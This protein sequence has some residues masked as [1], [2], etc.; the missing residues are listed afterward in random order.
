MILWFDI[1]IF[2]VSFSIYSLA[3][4]NKY[5]T[6]HWVKVLVTQLCPTLCDPINCSPPSSSVGRILQARILEWVAIPFSRGSSQS[7]NQTPGLLHCR[8]ILHCL[9]F[10]G[11]PNLSSQ[12]Y[13]FHFKISF[14]FLNMLKEFL[15]LDVSIYTCIT[16]KL[17]EN[18]FFIIY[19]MGII[20]Y[21]W[22]LASLVVQMEK[23]LPAMWET[24][25]QSLGWEDP[26]EKAMDTHSSTLA[27]KIPWTEEPGRLQSTGLQRVGHNWVT[28]LS[29]TL[30]IFNSSSASINIAFLYFIWDFI[31][32]HRC[33]HIFIPIFNHIY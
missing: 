15:F 21:Y 3:L 23:R 9:S 20:L 25:F 17:V 18:L 26:L 29:F 2:F 7:R 4:K 1:F 33:T 31:K 30:L 8:Q 32:I 27:W 13:F 16:M 10:Q 22:F 6:S 24:R 5:Q 14:L 12:L 11:S 28:S 19:A